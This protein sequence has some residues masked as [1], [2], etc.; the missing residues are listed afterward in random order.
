MEDATMRAEAVVKPNLRLIRNKTKALNACQNCGSDGALTYGWCK[1]FCCGDCHDDHH[2]RRGGKI[3]LV[4]C[5]VGGI[6]G[7]YIWKGL[8]HLLFG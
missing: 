5:L 2:Y 3:F 1:G 6:I 8:W 7:I 4:T